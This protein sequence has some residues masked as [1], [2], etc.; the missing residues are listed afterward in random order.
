MQHPW[1]RPFVLL[2]A[3][4]VGAAA[5]AGAET[6]SIGPKKNNTIY[7][8]SENT[9][10]G[11]QYF[12]AGTTLHNAYRRAIISFDVAGNVPAGSTIESAT[13]TLHMSRTNVGAQPVV[14]HLHRCLLPWGEGTVRGPSGEG[15]GGS[16]HPGD[17]TWSFNMFNTSR[18]RAPGGDFSSAS[19]G[20]TLVDNVAFY[21]WSSPGMAQ[22]VQAWLNADETNFGWVVLAEGE[23]HPPITAKRFDSRRN[24]ASEFQPVLRIVYNPPEGRD[25]GIPDAGNGGRPDAGQSDGGFANDGGIGPSDAGLGDDPGTGL[26]PDR[27]IAEFGRGGCQA[28]PGPALGLV[29]VSLVALTRLRRRR[30]P[31]R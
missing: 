29:A 26:R 14:V 20:S 23:G 25:G 18:W 5:S 19:S 4:E 16:P 1:G 2:L 24:V 28:V 10:G 17:A 6:V 27:I 12:F 15:G 8:E 11:G 21:S 30:Q 22:D 13:L 3:L 9:N 31:S 7:S